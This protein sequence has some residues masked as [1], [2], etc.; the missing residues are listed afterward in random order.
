MYYGL[1]LDHL[2]LHGFR[3]VGARAGELHPEHVELEQ[4][5]EAQLGAR[6]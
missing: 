2:G 5:L 4:L 3:I 6:G 1:D